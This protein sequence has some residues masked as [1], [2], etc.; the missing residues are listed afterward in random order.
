MAKTAYPE[1]LTKAKWDKEKGII[2]KLAKGETGVGAML[3]ELRK[4]YDGIP[5]D[6]LEVKLHDKSSPDDTAKALNEGRAVLNG[7]IEGV[8]KK[9]IEVSRQATKVSGDLKKNPLVP[10]STRE[11]LD[12]MSTAAVNFSA[13][14]RDEAIETLKGYE[15]AGKKAAEDDVEVQKEITALNKLRVD[16]AKLIAEALKEFQTDQTKAQ[17]ALEQAEGAAQKVEA[18]KGNP[19][20]A[21]TL[22]GQARTASNVVQK[23]LGDAQTRYTSL[24]NN[25]TVVD[26]RRG[27]SDVR[28]SGPASKMTG[29]A[30]TKGSQDFQTITTIAAAIKQAATR[31]AVAADKAE[32][33]AGTSAKSSGDFLKIAE[34]VLPLADKALADARTAYDRLHSGIRVLEEGIVNAKKVKTDVPNLKKAAQLRLADVPKQMTRLEQYAQAVENLS[35][36]LATIPGALKGDPKVAAAEKRIKEARN[37]I[38]VSRTSGVELHNKIKALAVQIEGMG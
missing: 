35:E 26:A 13:A 15:A 30:W 10:K 20:Q 23:V 36:R 11:Y 2:A 32:L 12:K 24:Q 8:R 19:T 3:D 31:A 4:V 5:W 1:L 9:A 38:G 22:A 17:T 29:A 21:K 28:V 7:P 34:E 6:K 27:N 16:A 37:Y 25:Q 18:A 33:A 14:L